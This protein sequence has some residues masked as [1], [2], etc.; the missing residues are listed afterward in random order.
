METSTFSDTNFRHP[1]ALSTCQNSCEENLGY[2]C[3][4]GGLP[5]RTPCGTGRSRMRTSL[6]PRQNNKILPV[7]F[8]HVIKRST[9][10]IFSSLIPQLLSYF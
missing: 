1:K 5:C 9:K 8:Y 10:F 7:E 6:P 3:S 4:G 2:L